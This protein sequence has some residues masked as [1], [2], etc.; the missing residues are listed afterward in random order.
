MQNVTPPDVPEPS[1]RAVLWQ[2]A[3]HPQQL[4]RLWNWKSA[5]LSLCLRGPV[6]LA[7][8]LRVSVRAG[9][10]ALVTESIF[11]AVVAGL[12]GAVV[13]SLRSAQPQW[14]TL[15]F[16]TVVLPA[17]A[18][19]LEYLLHWFRGTPH[20][21]F[22]ELVSIFISGVSAAFT[23]YAMRRSTLLVGSQGNPFTTD[24]RRLPRLVY[25][26]LAALPRAWFARH[27]CHRPVIKQ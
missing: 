1:F 19:A 9:V 23:W 8:S 24:L 21:R 25:N 3:C 27:E 20:L 11:C 12:Y 26:F 16:L 22:A 7:A 15:L 14:L 18:Q 4:V 2:L 10:S 5:L 13:Q 6:F 17:I